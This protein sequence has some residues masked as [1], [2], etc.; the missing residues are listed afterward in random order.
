MNFISVHGLFH[1]LHQTSQWKIWVDIGCIYQTF[2]E[3]RNLLVAMGTIQ[4]VTAS[5]DRY[6]VST[7]TK[8][9]KQLITGASS[10]MTPK[11]IFIE[12]RHTNPIAH[13]VL[14]PIQCR[15]QPPKWD[16]ENFTFKALANTTVFAL[17]ILGAGAD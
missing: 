9:A 13:Q 11:C 12:Y 2:H 7:A 6:G 14:N 10:S 3:A 17:Q 4:R 1:D 16:R 15:Y 5:T 8:T